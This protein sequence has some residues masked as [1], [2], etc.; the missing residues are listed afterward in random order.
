MSEQPEALR[1]ADLF[2]TANFEDGISTQPAADML[3]S[4]HELIGELVEALANAL[5]ELWY[6]RHVHMTRARFESELTAE[7]AA[8]SKAKGEQQ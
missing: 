2:D 5:N 3:R 8:L 1:I 4:Q 7:Y 6:D